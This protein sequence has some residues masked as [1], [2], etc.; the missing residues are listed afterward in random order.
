MGSAWHLYVSASGLWSVVFCV[1]AVVFFALGAY[2]LL[3]IDLM[4][5]AAPNYTRD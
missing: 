2:A 3:R 4:T 1:L 5:I